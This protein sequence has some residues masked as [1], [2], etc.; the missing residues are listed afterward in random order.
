MEYKNI[1]ILILLLLFFYSSVL[2]AQPNYLTISFGKV[3]GV[4]GEMENSST[5][6]DFLNNFSPIKI[7]KRDLKWR[8]VPQD[9]EGLSIESSYRIQINNKTNLKF[10][11]GWERM[12]YSVSSTIKENTIDEEFGLQNLFEV[13]I[14]RN[15]NTNTNPYGLACSEV[16]KINL[17]DNDMREFRTYSSQH[18]KFPIGLEYEL[19]DSRIKLYGGFYMMNPISHKIN[20]NC[21]L[22]FFNNPEYV[23]YNYNNGGPNV[24]HQISN[25]KSLRSALLG[26]EL[27]LAIRI[28]DIIHLEVKYSKNL[29]SYYNMD[30]TIRPD[31]ITGNGLQSNLDNFILS[32][33]FDFDKHKT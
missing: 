1:T 5:H 11:L 26:T 19:N 22:I 27:G 3:Y 4:F 12:R 17:D 30:E 15:N 28:I 21:N 2:K 7:R 6:Y 25:L 18:L 23:V 8:I 9:F 14:L 33:R 32:L 16:L 29:N 13:D 24:N 10:G 20:L 31:R